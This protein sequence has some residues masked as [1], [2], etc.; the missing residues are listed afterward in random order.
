MLAPDLFR[1]PIDWLMSRAKSG[2]QL[3]IRVGQNTLMILTALTTALCCPQREH[4][5]LLSCRGLIRKY[6]TWASTYHGQ[7]QD[8]KRWTN[9]KKNVAS[10]PALSV[11]ENT[12]DS[13]SEFIYLGSRIFT[14]G[15]STPEVMRRLALAASA[16]NQLGRVWRQSNRSLVTK[17][18]LYETCMRCASTVHLQCSHSGPLARSAGRRVLGPRLHA[19]HMPKEGKSPAS[20]PR[21]NILQ[22]SAI[23]YH[24]VR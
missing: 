12:V 13:V 1:R 23:L 16:M 22:T 11:G 20:N 4:R 5:L 6:G 9:K 8:P 21:L 24:C 19:S 2:G 18:C 17:P 15:Y 14:D 10:L 7:R 3:T